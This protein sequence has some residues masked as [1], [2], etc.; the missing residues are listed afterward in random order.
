MEKM[1]ALFE[2]EFLDY[3]ETPSTGV[4]KGKISFQPN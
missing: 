1:C 4:A 3:L 2:P